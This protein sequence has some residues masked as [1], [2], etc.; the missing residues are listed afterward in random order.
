MFRKLWFALLVSCLP[1]A[2]AA[3]Q[4]SQ[5]WESKA[6]PT[7]RLPDVSYAG[8]ACGEKPIPTIPVAANV[9][10]FGAKGDGRTDD[11]SA[12]LAAIQKTE[13]G[14]ILIPAG[15]YRIT[16]ILE[17]QK[18][19][20][21]LRGDGPDQSILIFPTPL[22][23]IR[24]NWGE[25]TGGLKT[26]NYSWSGGLIWFK[27]AD[28]GKTLGPVT[29]PAK[30]GDH[31]IHVSG[32]LSALKP[33]SWIEIQVKDDEKRSLL[34]YLYSGDPS[35]ISAI[36]PATH[37]TSFVTRVRGTQGDT[38]DLER[39]LRVDLRPE[40]KPVVRQFSPTVTNSG[41]EELGFEFPE[42]AY[43]GHFTELGYNAVA[44]NNVTDCWA[45]NLIITNS[46]SGLFAGAHFCTLSNIRLETHGVTEKD[47]LFGHHGITL[48]GHDN[49]CMRFEI[50]QKF[51][52]DL[53]VEGGAGNVFSSGSGTDLCFDHHKRA[54][55][56][57]V[58]TDLDAGAGTRLWKCGGGAN[59]GRQCGARGTFWNIRSKRPQSYPQGFG[60]ASMNLVA[61][62]TREK[63]VTETS[64]RW[65]EAIPPEKID[66]PDLYQAQ[67]KRRLDVR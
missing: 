17:I 66:P 65:F 15:R 6:D 18:P 26:S 4:P 8:Y 11:T 47:G 62:E 63:S 51:V 45:R 25:T 16:Q 61:L 46:D 24:P 27:G 2:A 37:R 42:R 58:F 36:K 53:S 21:V 32:N 5:L 7:G 44:F 52:H 29:R 55:Y 30:R 19:G 9:R 64:G 50:H 13:K 12:F 10:D 14:A 28:P 33:G 40:W 34:D 31:R 22:N 1:L 38:L 43:K 49:L 59:L 35:N 48:S 60:P 23:D 20:L 54:P 56:E 67:L 39:P 3:V 41:V 57:N